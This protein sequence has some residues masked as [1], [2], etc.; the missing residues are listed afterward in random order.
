MNEWLGHSRQELV[1]KYGEPA[2]AESDG[3]TGTIMVYADKVSGQ[4]APTYDYKIFYLNKEGK[5]YST[6]TKTVNIPPERINMS[7]FKRY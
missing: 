1:A 3:R 7:S 6:L 5:V 2:R 4:K